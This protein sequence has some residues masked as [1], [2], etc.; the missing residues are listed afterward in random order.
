ME[1]DWKEIL[2]FSQQELN[3]QEKERL[4]ENLSWMESDDI[5]LNF[6]DLK[7]LF[8]LAQDILKFKSE[9]VKNLHGQLETLRRAHEKKD[10]TNVLV[11]SDDTTSHQEEKISA[12]KEILEQLYL[13]IAELE[14]RKKGLINKNAHI[15][16]DSSRDVITEMETIDQ[17]E[18]DVLKK[19]NHIRKLLTDIKVLEDENT[20]LKQKLSTFKVKLKEATLLIEN[21]T[22]QLGVINEECSEL[23]ANLGNSEETVSRLNLEIQSLNKKLQ[24]KSSQKATV[25][26]DT[27]Q[28]LQNLKDTIKRQKMKLEMVS[29]ENHRLKEDLHKIPESDPT[30]SV[31]PDKKDLRIKELQE[32]LTEASQKII[33]SA[34]LINMLRIENDQLKSNTINDENAKLTCESK[35]ISDDCKEKHM[36]LQRQNKKLTNALREAENLISLREHEIANM[37]SQLKLLQSKDGINT[38][39]LRLKNKKQEIKFKDDSI[40]SLVQELNSVHELVNDLQIENETLRRQLNIPATEKLQTQGILKEFYDMKQKSLDLKEKLDRTKNRLV[41]FE[42]ENHIRAQNINKLTNMLKKFN[43]NQDKI[44]SV[45]KNEYLDIDVDEPKSSPNENKIAKDDI[46]E[47]DSKENSA[48]YNAIVEENEGLRN[49]LVELL[50]FLKDNS[51]TSSGVLT[52]ECPSLDNVLQ[53]MEARRAAG[54]LGPHMKTILELRAAIGGRDALLAALNDSRKET[55]KVM[56]QLSNESTK[57]VNLTKELLELKSNI[58]NF[59]DP[60]IKSFDCSEGECGSWILEN[61]IED[62]DVLDNNQL[63]AVFNK[64]NAFYINKVKYNFIYFKN[65]FEMLNDR[66]TSL[67]L[68]ATEDRY[69]WTIQEEKYKTVIEKF[70][71]QLNEE[72]DDERHS[73]GLI[74]DAHI[75]TL[76]SKCNYL[77]ENY[78]YIKNLNK[79]I[80]NEY[81]EYK[82]EALGKASEYENQIQNL[83]YE[84]TELI[85]KLH[86]SVPVELFRKQNITLV[87]YVLKYRNLIENELRSHIHSHSVTEGLTK[88]NIVKPNQTI[89][90][91]EVSNDMDGTDIGNPTQHLTNPVA[92]KELETLEAELKLKN[93]Q[94]GLLNT[95]IIELQQSLSEL[96]D[97]TVFAASSEEIKCMKEDL[98]MVSQENKIL[99]ENNRHLRT[100]LDIVST[101]LQGV[102]HNNTSHELEINVL[103][104]QILDLQSTNENKSTISR[105]SNELLITHLQVTESFEKIETLK[106]ALSKEQQLRRDAEKMLRNQKNVLYVYNARNNDRFR[107]FNHILDVFQQQYMGVLPLLSIESYVNSM[108][109][110]RDRENRINERV[111]EIDTLRENLIIKHSVSDQI[112]H[113]SKSKCFGHDSCEHKLICTVLEATK[114][115]ELSHI[116]RKNNILEESR[117]TLLDKCSYLERTLLLLNQGFQQSKNLLHSNT[118]GIQDKTQRENVELDDVKSDSDSVANDG[119]YTLS[120]PIEKTELKTIST[121]TSQLY[122]KNET[123]IAD[124]HLNTTST[125]T[126]IANYRKKDKLIQSDEDETIQ[127]LRKNYNKLLESREQQEKK[128]H[129]FKTDYNKQN[130]ELNYVNLHNSDLNKQIIEL[131]HEIESLVESNNLKD[132]LKDSLNEKVDSLKKQI[133]E[134][135]FKDKKKTDVD[136]KILEEK[137]ALISSIKKLEM[138]KNSIV[139]DYSKLLKSERDDYEKSIL[140]FQSKLIAL[141]AQLDKKGKSPQHGPENGTDFA[142]KYTL[143]ITELEDKCFNLNSDLETTKAELNSYKSELERWKNLA[144]ERLIKMEHLSEQLKERHGQEVESYKAENQHWLAQL[145]ETQREHYDLRVKLAEQKA[146]HLKQLANKDA[147]IEQLRNVNNN[148]KIQITSMHSMIATNDPSFDLS[149]IVEVEEASDVGSQQDS[150]HKLELKFVSTDDLIDSPDLRTSTAIWQEPVVERLRREKQL[151]SKQNTILRRQIKALAGR[152]K[153][154]R[155]DAQ[156]LKNQ[157]FRISTSGHK[158]A[159]AESAALQ[160]KIASLLAQLTS[161]RRDAHS[162]VALW[163]KWKRASQSSERWQA[164]YEEKCQELIKLESS[165]SLAKSAVARLEKEKRLLLSRLSECRSDKTVAIEK[166]ESELPEKPSRSEYYDCSAPVPA[167]ALLERVEAQQRRIVALEMADRGNEPLVTEYEKSLAEITSLKGQVLKLE[168]ALLEAQIQSPLRSSRDPKPELD[169]W[170][171]YCDMLKEENMQLTLR[172]SC[173]EGTNTSPV[174]H[175][176]VADLEQTVLTLRG[177]VSKLQAEQKSS[178]AV[179]K[180]SDSRPASGRSSVA[181]KGR[182]NAD[183]YRTEIAN[184]KRSIQEKDL[185]LEKSKE[186]LKIAADREDDLLREN[187][188]LRQR[189]EDMTE[190]RGRFLSV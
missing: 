34:N 144:S 151:I 84:V 61:Q 126:D 54:W 145:N 95:K 14:K 77:Q 13:D 72:N 75:F 186:M 142:V 161:A 52:L 181:D 148:L 132:I 73:P 103:R 166:Q 157:V 111:D 60:D 146:E 104:H 31:S 154:A 67:T 147:H 51:T 53:A 19:N 177:L 71:G 133:N 168:S 90:S 81:L 22:E 110:L 56:E 69:K 82:E 97:K 55:F 91:K 11:D 26:E 37:S 9:Q 64:S 105:L 89:D 129:E 44:D 173:L 115:M 172:V 29:A 113:L 57:C 45:L 131:K 102:T 134:Y 139:E 4:C 164:K 99:L 6:S 125:Q 185:L 124:R 141:N 183:T 1:A 180:R 106:V 65:K 118:Q 165:L 25:T 137:N 70:K 140:Y 8:K 42:M 190:N 127:E 152:E 128:L 122:E 187:M 27:H 119:T 109:E 78:S 3:E 88:I 7:T 2:N 153:R 112:I 40:K 24:E 114:E 86:N 108:T 150:D 28:K 20:S 130:Q 158:V 184:L 48:E 179:S 170:R 76:Q 98:L 121:Q 39:L 47:K 18:K 93:E 30:I 94:I 101:K 174:H 15:D 143:K 17:L 175:H 63:Q 80:R 162:S 156:N 36:K 79:N 85:E 23:K 83:M 123:L 35:N 12:N 160:N 66:L 49:S 178:A 171:S 117:K 155:L 38:L 188:M 120:I 176:R 32:K 167:R 33:S 16:S 189:L 169:Y 136:T 74:E 149:A 138:D 58:H 50:N 87:E 100:Q 21:L 163:D 43:V 182:P 5:E 62:I 159:T 41:T 68:R 116:L 10:H 46:I 59:E 107:N 96:I 135:S 92:P